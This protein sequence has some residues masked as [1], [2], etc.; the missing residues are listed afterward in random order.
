MDLFKLENRVFLDLTF[1]FS[2]SISSSLLCGFIFYMKP[3]YLLV[4]Q[5]LV[6]KMN[7]N[8]AKVFR[9]TPEFYTHMETPPLPLKGCTF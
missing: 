6:D 1:L 9:A 2:I 8:W 5:N 3:I 7:S 4:Y